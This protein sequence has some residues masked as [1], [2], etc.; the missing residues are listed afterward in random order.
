MVELLLLSF[1][2]L[3][4]VVSPLQAAEPIERDVRVTD[5]IGQ[6]TL[7]IADAPKRRLLLDGVTPLEEGDVL[8]TGPQAQAEITLDG[9]TVFALQAGSRLTFKKIFLHNTQL[10]LSK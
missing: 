2:A 6:V 3:A 9:A 4:S 5:A 8:E 1:L 10:E 7:K